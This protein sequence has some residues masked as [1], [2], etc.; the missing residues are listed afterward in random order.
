M[1]RLLRTR[2]TFCHARTI[3]RYRKNVFEDRPL[4]KINLFYFEVNR[5]ILEIMNK[6][7]F[8]LKDIKIK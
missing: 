3:A 5:D 8:K 2:D 6:Q 1:K 4:L 7:Q